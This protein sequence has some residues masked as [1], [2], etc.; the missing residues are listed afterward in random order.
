METIENK[1][2]WR[3]HVDHLKRLERSPVHQPGDDGND[4]PEGEATD[5]ESSIPQRRSDVADQSQDVD[6]ADSPS[7]PDVPASAHRYSLRTRTHPPHYYRPSQYLKVT[8]LNGY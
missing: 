3:R 8:I 6:G 4:E 7:T 2:L 5:E 1:L